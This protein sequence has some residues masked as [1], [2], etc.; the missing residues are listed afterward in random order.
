[1]IL[2]I[3]LAREVA[4]WQQLSAALRALDLPYTRIRA[5]DARRHM[6]LVRTRLPRP[7]ASATLGRD[8]T[9]AECCC[10]LSHLAALKAVLRQ[11]VPAAIILEDDVEI[12]HRF[13]GV[14]NVEIRPLRKLTTNCFEGSKTFEFSC[15]LHF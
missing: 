1:L 15:H 7:Y 5:I 10:A 11:P 14:L 6:D 4:Q 13:G 8:L 12:D 9:P 2:V 3:N